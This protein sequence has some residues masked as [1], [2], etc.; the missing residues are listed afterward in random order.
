[1]FGNNIQGSL[2]EFQTY[3]QLASANSFV[4]DRVSVFKFQA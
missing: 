1:M 2:L 3:L 4:R